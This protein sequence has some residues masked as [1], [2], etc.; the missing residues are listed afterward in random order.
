MNSVSIVSV[1]PL[2]KTSFAGTEKFVWKLAL[3]MKDRGIDVE[4]LS[5]TD[6]NSYHGIPHKKLEGISLP[7]DEVLIKKM[8]D[9]EGVAGIVKY[10]SDSLSLYAKNNPKDL[11]IINSPLFCRC[12]KN[13]HAILVLHDNPN[14]LINYFGQKNADEFVDIIKNNANCPIITPSSYYQEIFGNELELRITTI[15]HSLDP[16]VLEMLDKIKM[17]STKPVS[18]SEKVILVPSRLEPK[19]KG[20]DLIIKAVS[21]VLKKGANQKVTIKLSGLD[22]TYKENAVSL[23]ELSEK[24]GINIEIGNYVNILEE[25]AKADIIC[26][27]SR[28]E[29]FGYAAQ[30]SI[31]L[32]KIT[33]L[34][35][36]PTYKEISLG[37]PNA[38]IFKSESIDDLASKISDYLNE[39]KVS[40]YPPN[41]WYRRYDPDAW[42]EKYM[43]YI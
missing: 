43:N 12:T 32:G 22:E 41:E 29:S 26:L 8:M 10:F 5:P 31:A 16:K 15:P 9:T 38:H 18:I 13:L 33:I 4:C 34:S 28:Y 21:K 23:R 39:D 7:I 6:E 37:A 17:E 30:E 20:Q 42:V 27:P 35:D 36:I 14:E 25:I 1:W 2:S 11:Y 40:T 3:L 24:L 19:Q